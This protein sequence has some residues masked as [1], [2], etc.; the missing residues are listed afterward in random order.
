MQL[1]R[2]EGGFLCDICGKPLVPPFA[3]IPTH[4]GKI[5]R[6]CPCSSP[7][8]EED[9]VYEFLRGEFES[10][11]DRARRRAVKEVYDATCPACRGRLRAML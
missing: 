2:V 5:V 6:L 9:C 8:K 10:I 3:T 7:P 11:V 4:Q 1:G